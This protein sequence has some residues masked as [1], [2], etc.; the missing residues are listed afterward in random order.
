M[1]LWC[2]CVP[3]GEECVKRE[4]QKHFMVYHYACEGAPLRHYSTTT[5]TAIVHKSGC[6]ETFLHPR[7]T[8]NAWLLTL[9]YYLGRTRKR[10]HYST[11][12]Q[13]LCGPQTET[14]ESHS[15]L[16]T[17]VDLPTI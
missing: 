16:K 10:G 17:L 13:T 11:R 8:S 5:T 14:L 4:S 15:G 9:L 2:R 1:P 12:L 3:K 7:S 6:G